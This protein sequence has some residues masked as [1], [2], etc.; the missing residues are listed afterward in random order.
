[1]HLRGPD[2]LFLKAPNFAHTKEKFYGD[3]DILT[4][5]DFLYLFQYIS[6]LKSISH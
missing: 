1:M 5:N 3:L 6:L 2:L 4:V